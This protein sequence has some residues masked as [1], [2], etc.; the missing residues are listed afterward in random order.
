MA[1]GRAGDE[2]DVDRVG[3]GAGDRLG[4][5]DALLHRLVRERRA[6]D[7]VADREH[8]LVRGA[9]EVVDL[10][11]AVLLGLDLGAG[12]VERL[13][14]GSAPA[15]DRQVVGLALGVAD[16]E[17]HRLA[18][19]DHVGDRGAREDVDPLALEGP[20]DHAGHVLVLERQDLGQHLDQRHL[21]PVADVGGGDL[22]ARCPGADD[23]QALRQGGQRPGPPGVDDPLGELDPGDRQLDRAGREDHRLGLVGVGADGDVAG[24]GQRAL[25]VDPGDLVLV[26]EHLDPV[27]EP[28]RDLGPA[29]GQRL[30]VDRGLRDLHPELGA[31]QR[32]VVDL[33]RVEHRLRGDAGVVEAAPARLVLLD[34]RRLQAQLGG[35]DRRHVAAGTAAD[36]DH[37]VGISHGATLYNGPSDVPR[38]IDRTIDDSPRGRGVGSASWPSYS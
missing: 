5:D 36:H 27:R 10:D 13:G 19:V 29:L 4:R 37:V 20:L 2:V 9:L 38:S 1:E 24:V 35:P 32:V 26:P 33:G 30:P 31:V 16:L 22:R 28:G 3:R 6:A 12:Q 34:D 8:L 18:R 14:V 25:A 21:G 23:R 17:L 15:G 7:Q 11:L